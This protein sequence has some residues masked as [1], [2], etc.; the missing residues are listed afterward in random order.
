MRLSAWFCSGGSELH[1]GDAA[2]PNQA[3]KTIPDWSRSCTRYKTTECHNAS[4]NADAC[5]TGRSLE[6]SEVHA[7]TCIHIHL[8]CFSQGKY[9]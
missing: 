3:I 4:S 9:N 2:D 5:R 8:A 1:S 6:L 7:S